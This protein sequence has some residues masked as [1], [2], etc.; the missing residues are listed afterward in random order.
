MV[1]HRRGGVF[2]LNARTSA[3]GWAGPCTFREF[4]LEEWPD[5]RATGLRGVLTHG[6]GR[7]EDRRG[8]LLVSVA[9][10]GRGT[11]WSA[12]HL[13]HWRLDTVQGTLLPKPDLTMT[14]TAHD[15]F[16]VGVHLDSVLAN[17]HVGD[18]RVEF[19]APRL[20]AGDTLFTLQGL[21]QWSGAHWTVDLDAAR[22][23]SA[24]FDWTAEPPMRLSGDARGT[25]FDRV[26]AHDGAAHLEVSGRWA[27][28]EGAYDCRLEGHDLDK[29]PCR[30][31][32]PAYL[33]CMDG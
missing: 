28:P 22:A 18:Q 19:T 30:I 8:T 20:V 1:G 31:A 32:R 23:H 24:Q 26:V 29:G 21:G 14:L 3:T 9:L 33:R 25:V 11:D 2:T 13:A 15:G 4:P 7:V 17:L 16:F 27:S 6:E 10:E 12:A 5:G